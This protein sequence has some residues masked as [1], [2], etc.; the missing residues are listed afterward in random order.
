MSGSRGRLE[1][2]V[3]LITGAARGQG[4]AEARLFAAEGAKV[5]V[6]DVLDA[7]GEAVAKEIGD[8]ARFVHLD[9][10]EE[11]EWR[12]A[13]ATAVDDFGGLHALVNNAGVLG[14]FTPLARTAVED[15]KKTI[16]VNLVGTFLGLK[17]GGEVI[18]DSGGGAIVNISSVGGLW[19]IPYAS[20]YVASKFG[21]RGMTKSAAIELG[22]RGVRVNSVHP[23]GVKTA[24]SA[25]MGDDGSSEWY[26]RLPIPRIGT[27]DDIAS[28]VLFLACDDAAYIT[29]A[30]LLVDGG[31]LSGDISLLPLA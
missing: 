11:G 30:E 5:V 20:A 2:K 23:G 16:D 13:I 24:M 3:A 15:F 9:V 12:D 14:A 19:G 1:G 18:A 31:A 29:G 26:R 10:T 6:A 28:A 17:H 22:R 8:D 21:V 4:E 25:A 27:V 7:E